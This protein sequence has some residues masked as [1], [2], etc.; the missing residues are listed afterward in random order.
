MGGAGGLENMPTES[1]EISRSF[2]RCFPVIGDCAMMLP[3]AVMGRS[4]SNKRPHPC[5]H[6][7]Q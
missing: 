6:K 5:K 7:P 2:R 3:A 1:V 4:G